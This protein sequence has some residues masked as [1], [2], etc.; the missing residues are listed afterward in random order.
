MKYTDEEIIAYLEGGL[1]ENIR[2]NMAAW[3]ETSEHAR[4][5]VSEFQEL[6][7]VFSDSF[8]YEPSPEMLYTFREKIAEQREQS[9]RV[10]KWY[11]IAAAIL[12]MVAGFGAGRFTMNADQSTEQ[13]SDLKNEVRVLQQMV[14][15]NTLKD[16][17]ASERLQVIN[18]IEKTPSN[19]DEELIM[20]LVRTMNNDESPNVRFASVQALRK[21]IDY[22]AVTEQMVHS[23]GEQ[24]DPLVQIAMI[25]FLTEAGEKAAIAPLTKIANNENSPLEVRQSAELALNM[26]I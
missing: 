5:R 10:Y 3:I 18:M 4:N 7:R 17:S 19:L 9:G 16:H 20:A 15:M 13:L 21:F 26:L 22:E 2:R 1:D 23:L 25:N 24:D 8:N 6:E 11:R 14:M 12:L